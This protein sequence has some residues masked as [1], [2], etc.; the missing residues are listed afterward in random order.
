MYILE[1]CIPQQIHIILSLL[2]YM[3]LKYDKYTMYTYISHVLVPAYM[4]IPHTPYL[5]V[6][7]EIG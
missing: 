3:S 6:C 7:L 1:V 2:L 4:H 5:W